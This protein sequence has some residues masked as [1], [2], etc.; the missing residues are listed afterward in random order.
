[1]TPLADLVARAETPEPADDLVALR[2]LAVGYQYTQL[3]AVTARL[4]LIDAISAGASSPAA[5]AAAIGADEHPTTVLLA[6][7]N[8]L[9]LVHFGPDGCQVTARGSL[10]RSDHPAGVWAL[11]TAS[12]AERYQAW[13]SLAHTLT[14]GRP[15][16]PELFGGTRLHD[17]YA[18]EPAASAVFNRTMA[19]LSTQTV[20]DI[21]DVHS[22]AQH[23]LLADIGGGLSV[24]LTA[25]LQVTPGLSGVLVDLPHVAAAALDTINRA[26]LADRCQAVGIDARTV[27]PPADAYLF[28]MVL[29]DFPDD[30]A[31]AMLRGC[32]RAAE[33]EAQLVIIDRLRAADSSDASV[34]T[35]MSTLNLMVMT[36]SAERTEDD[37]AAL[38]R[39]AGWDLRDVHQTRAL[40]GDL[41]YL[42]AV[43]G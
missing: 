36:G 40:G 14:S 33:P 2:E 42:R 13:G 32:R 26:G 18:T 17:Y 25:I 9:G 22:W 24:T 1:M 8:H 6:I 31:T 16:F 37:Y 28:R 12:G 3:L 20:A 34:Q 5:V 7:L 4:R 10:V 11:L 38:L 43:A 27:A 35:L 21:L 41:H 23:R 19:A 30:D 15:S 29:C 39:T